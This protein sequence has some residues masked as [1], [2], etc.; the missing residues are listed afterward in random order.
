MVDRNR[1]EKRRAAA[2]RLRA[3]REQAG[4]ATAKDASDHFGWNY[5]TYRSHEAGGK[6]SRGFSEYAQVYAD[7]FGTTAAWL[8]LE[9][10]NTS[11]VDQLRVANRAVPIMSMASYD[12]LIDVAN[13]KKPKSNRTLP[14]G[15][16][17]DLSAQTFAVE[18]SGTSMTSPTGRSFAPGDHVV[19][20]PAAELAPGCFVLVAI[21]RHGV[22]EILFRKFTPLEH[23]SNETYDLVPLNPDFATIRVPGQSTVKILGRAALR[24]EYM[25]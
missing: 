1:G 24:V 5:P 9:D 15:P 16:G 23:G 10:S 22:K 8:L 11:S 18:I 19:I 14:I 21:E 12:D 3:A 17:K 13:G 25:L 20:D 6:G 4:Y 2:T 7:A